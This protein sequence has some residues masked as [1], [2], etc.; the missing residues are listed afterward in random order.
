MPNPSKM[1]KG[2][3][4]AIFVFQPKIKH[5]HNVTSECASYAAVTADKAT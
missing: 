1:P 4:I 5:I 3:L 2:I